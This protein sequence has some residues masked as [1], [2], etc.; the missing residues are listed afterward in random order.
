M[1]GRHR[2]DA[3]ARSRRGHRARSR[4]VARPPRGRGAAMRLTRIEAIRY[5]G[6]DGQS[7]DGL[8]EGLSVVL[9]PNEAGKTSLISLVRHVLYGFPDRRTNER[10]YLSAGGTR[11]GR[12]LFA[13]DDGE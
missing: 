11:E 6:I 7:V 2:G 8:G 13:A 1:R 9:G 4:E 10:G 5:G 3:R 12:L